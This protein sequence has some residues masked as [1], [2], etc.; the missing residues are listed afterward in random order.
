MSDGPEHLEKS[1]RNYFIFYNT[2]LNIF[3]HEIEAKCNEP[4]L[5][6]SSLFSHS[7]MS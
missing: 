3:K 6:I 1:T 2:Y 4:I 5:N 7:S